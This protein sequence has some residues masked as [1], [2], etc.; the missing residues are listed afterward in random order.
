MSEMALVS[1]KKFKLESAKNL[2]ESGANSALELL[3]KPSKFFSTTQIGITLIGIVLGYYSGDALKDNFAAIIGKVSILEPYANQIAGPIIVLFITYIS[4]VFGELFPKQLGIIFPEK[5]SIAV[6]K[7]M[8]VLSK[9]MSPFVWLLTSSNTLLMRIFGIQKNVK[10]NVSEEEI[11]SIIRDSA[12]GGEIQDV[13]Q[14]IVERV[15]ELG[16]TKAQNLFTHKSNLVYF[17]FNDS[18]EEIISKINGEPHSAYPVSENHNTDDVKGIV[19]INDLFFYSTDKI[20]DLKDFIKEPIFVSE[21]TSAYTILENFRESKI[22]FGIVI[23]EYGIT[24]GMITMDD[25]MDALVGDMSDKEKSEFKITS[26]SKNSWVVDGQFSLKNFSKQFP[27]NID[28]DL[29]QN[30]Q[31]IAGFVMNNF[32]GVPEKGDKINF[33]NFEFEIL[34][35]DNQRIDKI[36]V[37]NKNF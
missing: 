11:K 27:I 16:D 24:Q 9:I 21:N 37:T 2:G 18:Y 25:M 22:Q 3:K 13:E 10:S 5:I 17:D 34:S 12:K 8:T 23:D 4:I 32:E 6:S 1:S 7:T 33:E 30:I 19:L 14:D 36:L 35:K 31:T 29:F 20:F 28:D 15:F 26:K